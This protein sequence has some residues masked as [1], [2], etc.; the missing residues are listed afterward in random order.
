MFSVKSAGQKEFM[1]EAVIGCVIV[2]AILLFG[3][4]ITGRNASEDTESAVHA[5]SL[6]YLD[7]LAERR[8]QVVSS[9]LAGYAANMD[10]AVGLLT[11]DDLASV[12]KLQAYQARMKQLY[13]LE[14]FAFVD[15]D[16][17]IYTSRGTRT[18]IQLYKF[19]YN[20]IAGPEV[21][22][23]NADGA[24]KAVIA[25][26]VDR[27]SLEGKTLVACF[28][29]IDMGRMLRSL[30]LQTDNNNTTFCNI[31]TRKGSALSDMV[32]GGLASEDNLLEALGH[33]EF[34]KG[35]SFQS[36]AADFEDGRA[37]V[38]SFT[39]GTIRETLCYVPIKGTDWMLTYLVRDSVINEQI[40]PIADGI[41]RRS[42]AQSALT[43]VALLAVFAV[44][45]L[46]SRRAAQM[47]LEKEVSEAENRGKQQEL[48]EQLALQEELLA[49]EQNKAQQE[50]VI[51]SLAANYRSVYYVDLDTD[52]AVCYR[53]DDPLEDAPNLGEHFPYHQTFTSYGE[54]FVNPEYQGEFFRFI[55]PGEIRRH[56]AEESVFNYRYLAKH[57]GEERYE[58]LRISA[59]NTV[60]NETGMVVHAVCMGFAD[61]DAEMRRDL[62]RKQELENAVQ[63]ARESG[64]AA[65]AANQ[66]KSAFLSMMSHEIRTPINAV[67]GMNEM[68]LR[69]SA[70]ENVLT[71]AENARAASMSLLSIINDI[72]DFSK[73]EAGKMDILPAEYAL[74]S[75]VNDLV[76]LVRLRAEE[77]GLALYVKVDP[78]TPNTLFG[79]EIRVKQIITNILTNAVKYTEKGSVSFSI[80]FHQTAPDEIA[81]DVSVTDTGRGIKA[82]DIEKL[83]AAFNRLDAEKTRNI[84][85]T[86]LGLNITQQLLALMGSRLE[87]RSVLGK[88]STFSFS[89]PQKVVDWEGVGDLSAALKRMEAKRVRRHAGFVAPNARILVVDDAPMNIAVISGLLRRTRIFVDTASSGEECI[90]KFGANQYDLVFL[91]H[92]MPG[93]DGMETLGELRRLYPGKAKDTPIISLTANAVFGAKEEYLAAG[94]ADY[95]SKPVMPDA[96]DEMILKH[97]PADKLVFTSVDEDDEDTPLPDWLSDIPLISTRRGVEFCGGNQEYLDALKIFAASIEERADELERLY[98]SHDY[99]EYTVKVHALKSMAKSIGAAELSELAAE[100]EEAGKNRDIAALTA[101]AEVLLSLYRS[102]NE[103]LKR[104]TEETPKQADGAEAEKTLVT[105]RRHTLLLVDD[106]EDFLALVTRW[107]KKDYAVTAVNSGS[108]ALKYLEKERPD[109]VLLDY[110][111]PEMN[112]A[113]VLEQI[114]ETQRLHDLPVAFLTGTEDKENIRKAEHLH[115]DGFLPKS[116]GKKGLLMG[117]ATFFER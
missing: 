61:V 43:A 65:E 10:A 46:Q 39:Y 4:I 97:L 57:H 66:A 109:L 67:I 8:A 106:D 72:L 115:P 1:K 95:L 56:L 12:A 7:E 102:L 16:G 116:M 58:Q 70:E 55:E 113:D 103:P 20:H 96:L 9:T 73:I 25:M 37:G 111:M 68:I 78:D 18:D 11:T 22:L 53:A 51:N 28:M 44:L 54:R 69:E 36:V 85:G 89:L 114:R 94:F 15:S 100:M 80:G 98:K 117:I 30:S 82:E 13:G 74:P 71:Y 40:S 32:L 35:H 104:L 47:T 3:T 21:S 76:N 31:Y 24:K 79:D 92:R 5:V 81:L 52:D 17:L 63:A 88:G 101:G 110:E 87:V 42:L 6:M 108:K 77:H 64:E 48:E 84:E 75:L 41:A 27:L 59:A 23:K 60:A 19:D 105:D 26:P 29:E 49:Q 112:G 83:F 38:V 14:K 50:N 33:A 34:K 45:Y 90:E 62:Q 107:L 93:M 2:A 91:D 86:G 99:K